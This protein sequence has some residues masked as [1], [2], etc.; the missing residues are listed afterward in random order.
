[1]VVREGGYC[2]SQQVSLKTSDSVSFCLF[3]GSIFFQLG[4]R[5]VPCGSFVSVAVAGGRPRLLKSEPA[6]LHSPHTVS[7]Q[8]RQDC[9]RKKTQTPI[10]LSAQVAA[11]ASDSPAERSYRTDQDWR[12]FYRILPSSLSQPLPDKRPTRAAELDR[13]PGPVWSWEDE[14][15]KDTIQGVGALLRPHHHSPPSTSLHW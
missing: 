2:L 3:F 15:E 13:E 11:P 7:F 9:F 1:M 14:R 8:R 12:P 6:G 10:L 4:L 5:V